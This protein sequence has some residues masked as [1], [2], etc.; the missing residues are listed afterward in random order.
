MGIRITDNYLV[1]CCGILYHYTG[2]PLAKSWCVGTPR[3]H[4]IAA[5]P[6]AFHFHLSNYYVFPYTHL[7]CLR[8]WVEAR[9][10]QTDRLTPPVIS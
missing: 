10:R 2:H 9:D 8:H 6:C 5:W 1:K 7:V 4:M 3:N